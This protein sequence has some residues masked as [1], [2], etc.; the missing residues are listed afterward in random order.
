[1]VKLLGKVRKADAKTS[2]DAVDLQVVVDCN[3]DGE[4][5]IRNPARY[6]CSELIRSFG[7]EDWWGSIKEENAELL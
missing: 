5:S 2:F 6:M 1:M 3:W 7:R 4:S